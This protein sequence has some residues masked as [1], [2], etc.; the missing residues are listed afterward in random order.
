MSNWAIKPLFQHIVYSNFLIGLSA[1]SLSAGTAYNYGI[2]KWWLY[3]ITCFCAIL[4]VYNFQ[5]LYKAKKNAHLTPWLIWV[6]EHQSYLKSLIGI[7]G[8]IG[9][10][11]FVLLIGKLEI[12]PLILLAGFVSLIYVVPFRKKSLREIAYLKSPV[13]AFVWTSIII[14]FPWVNEYGISS[15]IFPELLAYF[16]YFVALTIAFDIRDLKHDFPIQKTTPQVVGI[17][18]SKVFSYVLISLFV[19]I[20]AI[21]N[22]N[23]RYNLVFYGGSLSSILLILGINNQRKE[24]YY[25]LIDASMMVIGISYFV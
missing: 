1:F 5:R 19:M 4:S 9:L 23:M 6:N 21:V 2:E 17:K 24:G 3:G 13:I 18:R 15:T 14:A 16:Y 8:I 11:S 25:A 20:I 22:E 12:I 10:I 7:S